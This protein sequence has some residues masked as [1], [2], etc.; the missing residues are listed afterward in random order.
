M[1]FELRKIIECNADDVSVWAGTSLDHKVTHLTITDMDNLDLST[2][3]LRYPNIVE[4]RLM[5]CTIL[6]DPDVTPWNDRQKLTWVTCTEYTVAFVLASTLC[7]L[8][9]ILHFEDYMPLAVMSRA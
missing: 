5:N 9:P 8:N 6:T 3:A 2:V 1:L 4:L 7:K